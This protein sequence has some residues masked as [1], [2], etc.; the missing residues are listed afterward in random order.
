[1]LSITLG[2]AIGPFAGIFWRTTSAIRWCSLWQCSWLFP[3]RRRCFCAPHLLKVKGA[4]A[5]AEANQV[6]RPPMPWRCGGG[7]PGRGGREDAAANRDEG[8]G[9]SARVPSSFGRRSPQ[10]GHSPLAR[11][12]EAGVLPISVVCG[13][14]FF[15]IPACS[16]SSPYATESRPGPGR[17]RVLRRVRA[18]P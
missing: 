12:V 3:F 9:Y 14:L 16:R 10:G 11:F 4:E 2:S 18:G 13:L 1:M 5:A 7:G 15:A 6:K 8:A 17:Q